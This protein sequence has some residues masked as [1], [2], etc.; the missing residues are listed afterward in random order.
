[1][2]NDIRDH[3]FSTYAELSEKLTS[4]TPI[5]T[6]AYLEVRNI[7]FSENFAHAI[8]DNPL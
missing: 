8:I 1:M 5:H 3:S 4:V 7:V 6:H 2:L